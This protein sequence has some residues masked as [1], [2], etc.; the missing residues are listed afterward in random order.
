MHSCLKVDLTDRVGESTASHN[1]SISNTSVF[2]FASELCFYIEIFTK[3]ILSL[4]YNLTHICLN[5]VCSM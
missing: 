3:R 4:I 5:N 2:Q 1:I